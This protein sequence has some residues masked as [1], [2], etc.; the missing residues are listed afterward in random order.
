LIL[1]DMYKNWI[2]NGLSSLY[3]VSKD[4][5]A[6]GFSL[7]THYGDEAYYF[8]SAVYEVFKSEN[9]SHYLQSIIMDDLKSKGIKNYVLGNVEGNSLLN[10]PDKKNKDI[11]FF[12][13]GFGDSCRYKIVSEYFMDGDYYKKVMQER[14]ENYLGAEYN[15]KADNISET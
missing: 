13:S 8:M 2:Y 7:V 5:T 1:W 9:V 4:D 3:I 11:A 15:E 14:L 10:C 6:V 12:K